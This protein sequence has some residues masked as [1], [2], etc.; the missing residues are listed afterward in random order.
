[1]VGSET[2]RVCT[3]SFLWAYRGLRRRA[4]FPSDPSNRLSCKEYL[5]RSTVAQTA[6]VPELVGPWCC[7][8]QWSFGAIL[9]LGARCAIV[10]N[11]LTI[12]AAR[13]RP[14]LRQEAD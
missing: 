5:S 3:I 4:L 8:L 6:L 2:P 10:L 7:A 11:A 14:P 9:F 12:Y 13:L 1:M